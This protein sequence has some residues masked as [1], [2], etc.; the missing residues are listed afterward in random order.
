MMEEKAIRNTG[1]DADFENDKRLRKLSVDPNDPGRDVGEGADVYGNIATAEQFGYVHRGSVPPS[2]PAP[3]PQ[4]RRVS[5]V[6][7]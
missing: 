1:V 6:V 7:D 5:D 3:V 2:Q 4:T